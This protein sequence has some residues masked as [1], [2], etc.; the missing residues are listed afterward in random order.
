MSKKLN[1][2]TVFVLSCSLTEEEQKAT[3]ERIKSLISEH[4]SIKTVDEWGKRHLAY[5]INKQKEGIYTLIHFTAENDFIAELERVY[6]I[7]E[8]LMRSIVIKLDAFPDD[9]IH[10]QKTIA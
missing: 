9:I 1:Y 7:L 2:E 10:P 4:G 8:G 3:V 5:P 6:G